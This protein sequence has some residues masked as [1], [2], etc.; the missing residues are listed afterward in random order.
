MAKRLQRLQGRTGG[1]FKTGASGLQA[2]FT[3]AG[4]AFKTWHGLHTRDFAHGAVVPHAIG[5][6][7]AQQQARA[8]KPVEQAVQGHAVR[9][10]QTGR[11]QCGLQLQMAPRLAGMT[12]H[13]LQHRARCA[14]SPQSV[15]GQQRINRVVR[16]EGR[17]GHEF[18]VRGAGKV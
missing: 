10:G 8:G 5:I 6:H 17:A 18:V 14:G 1:F 2:D 3:V 11:S 12:A 13:P 4:L 15:G 9:N 7:R 16:G